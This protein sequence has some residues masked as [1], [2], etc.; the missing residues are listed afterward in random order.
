LDTVQDIAKRLR[1]RLGPGETIFGCFLSLGSPLTAEI[2]AGF[3]LALIDLEHGA[4]LVTN[5]MP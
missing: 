4:G 2:V 1:E 3:E 5:R